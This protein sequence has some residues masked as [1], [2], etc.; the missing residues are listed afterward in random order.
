M[1]L[2]FWKLLADQSISYNSAFSLNK[3]ENIED[4]FQPASDKPDSDPV[5]ITAYV[6]D[7]RPDTDMLCLFHPSW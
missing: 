4:F 6:P 1:V 5:L 3:A 7:T 2:E